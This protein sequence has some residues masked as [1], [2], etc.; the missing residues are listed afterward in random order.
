MNE[1]M[2][3]FL[4]RFGIVLCL[5]AAAE[6]RLV[7]AYRDGECL[8][9]QSRYSPE[10]DLVIRV[11][12]AANEEAFLI[13]RN[14]DL[15]RCIPLEKINH[16]S[17]RCMCRYVTV[18]KVHCNTD[19][20]PA[21]K[22][23]KYSF[24]SGNHGSFYGRYLKIPGHGLTTADIGGVI[25]DEKQRKLVIVQVP[26]KDR[27]FVHP[28]PVNS[29]PVGRAV[30]FH[31]NGEK[32]FYRGK[33]L[34][35]TSAVTGQMRPL[36]R[37]IRN[38]F[39]VDGE[40]PL[41][42]RTVVRCRFVDHILIHD[43]IAPE[44]VTEYLKKNPGKKPYPEF[45]GLWHMQKVDDDPR[46]ADYRK[47]PA[48]INVSN[49]F[50]YQPWGCMVNYRTTK[51]LLPVEGFYQM[52]VNF[53]WVGGFSSR[54]NE[55]FY[56]PK[57]KKLLLKNSR[58]GKVDIP[59]DLAANYRMPKDMP[60]DYTINRLRDSID[61]SNP[62]DRFIRVAG[63]DRPEYGIAV[64]YSLID[65]CTALARR[66]AGRPGVFYLYRTKK[67]YPLCYELTN[68]VPGTQ[69]SSVSYKQY[70]NPANDPDATGFYYHWENDS[71]L[72]YFDAHKELKNKKLNLPSWTIGK[73][74]TVVEKTP[75][76]EFVG[77]TD[78]VTDSGVVFNLN[79][80]YGYLVLKLD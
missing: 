66:G 13:P 68:P 79:G 42:D 20:Y 32:L 47:L 25:T 39:L 46:M 65:G 24:L 59:C 61:P 8:L 31:L 1:K 62:P 56:V 71:L 75:S 9:V 49:R 29:A 10:E 16:D 37:V 12:R 70:F 57:V 28:E 35:Y 17:N 73:K 40:K 27:I 76:V 15:R 80:N 55:F 67:M 51:V 36:N 72:V 3:K 41:P 14:G 4:I 19:E 2:K 23:Y 6:D 7:T 33:P 45:S 11:W 44:A 5:S 58:T 22:F 50:R 69:V 48:L 60:V 30:F 52:E 77:D 18:K 38:E 54:K 34:N 78:K 64:G 43:V 74:I 53:G 26:D 21:T 63:D